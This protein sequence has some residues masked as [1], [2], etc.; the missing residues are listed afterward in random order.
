MLLERTPKGSS[1]LKIGLNYLKKNSSKC[2]SIFFI[3]FQTTAKTAQGPNRCRHPPVD[4]DPKSAHLPTSPVHGIFWGHFFGV[5]D[6]VAKK[7]PLGFCD[8]FCP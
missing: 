7:T 8:Q 6:C 3:F 4:E 5:V 2:Q 1:A